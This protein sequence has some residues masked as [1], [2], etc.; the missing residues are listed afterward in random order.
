MTNEEYEILKQSYIDDFIMRFE[1]DNEDSHLLMGE[2]LSV[3]YK[4]IFA[5]GDWISVNEIAQKI[6]IERMAAQA[7]YV[8]DKTEESLHN[9]VTQKV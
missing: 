2:R 8:S 7:G 4:E 1:D 3:V 6:S 5:R 9:T